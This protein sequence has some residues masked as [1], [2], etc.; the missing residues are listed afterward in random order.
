[1]T[2]PYDILTNLA[3]NLA[4][5]LL[6][7]GAS[8]LRDYAFGDAETRALRHAWEAAFRALL[9]SAVDEAGADVLETIFRNFVQAEGVAAALLDL[10]LAGGPP[11]L[12]L[13]R[14]RFDALDYDRAT[15]PVDFNTALCALTEGLSAALLAEAQTPDSPL[16]NRVSLVRTAAI[17]ALLRQ[18]HADVRQI[19]ATVARLEAQLPTAKYNLVF[20]GPASGFAVGDRAQA[21]PFAPPPA[22]PPE[23]TPLLGQAL[24]LLTS[25]ARERQPAPY[26]PADRDAYLQAVEDECKDIHLFYDTEKGATLPLE[27]IYV[28][29]KADLSSSAER[30]AS[31][32]LMKQLVEE[33]RAGDALPPEKAL[34]RV[35]ILD[36]YA[37]RYLIY[38]PKMQAELR[39]AA[40]EAQERT[41]HLAEIVRRYRWMVL[42]GDPGSGKST[43]ARW[44]AL[45][46][47]RALLAGEETLRVDGGHV[48]PDAEPGAAESLGAARLPVLVRIAEYAAARWPKPGHDTELRLLAYVGQRGGQ[49]SERATAFRALLRDYLEAG[50]VTFIL[51][52]LDE[53]TEY[54]QR[55]AIAA[56]IEGLIGAWVRDAA[57]RCPLDADYYPTLMAEPAG[58]QGNQALVTSRIVGYQFCPLHAALPHFVIQPMEDAAVRRFC[59]NWGACYGAPEQGAAL[60]AAVL[61]HPNPNVREQ[62]GRNPLL[63]TILAQVF[64]EN[65]AAGLPA[66]RTEL[67]REAETAVFR[68]RGA[69]WARLAGQL[70][71]RDLVA[72][73]RRITARVAF[74]LHANPDFPAALVDAGSV[75]QWLRTAVR[76]EPA[77]SSGRREDD[78]VRE[79]LAAAGRLS[80]FFVARGENAYGFLHRQFQEYFAGRYLA[81]LLQAGETLTPYLSRLEDPAWREVLLL[82]LGILEREAPRLT[83]KVMHSVLDASDPTGGLLPYT[84]LLAADALQELARPPEALVRRVA[85]GLITAYSRADEARFAALAKRVRATF[86][87]LPRQAQGRD[88]VGA[89]LCAALVPSPPALPI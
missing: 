21:Q 46:L 84:L 47:A 9:E 44:L 78:V 11:P 72:A 37:A 5:D 70:G 71:T 49:D 62:M 17:H 4:S 2:L 83:E 30:K 60:A 20:L 1:M 6:T 32:E 80:G 7:G 27:R 86:A 40:R 38:D 87:A 22:L 39:A 15:L 25:L 24:E 55:A 8:A 53:V 36:P 59:E 33:Q 63:L 18:Q 43:L 88:P 19:A 82:T 77:L 75:R 12:D 13:L 14:A 23:L 67:Y 29:L 35:M 16:Y 41:Y 28:A 34:A 45:H 76:D 42:L 73:L 89:A 69:E 85:A 54:D 56:E 65:P 50:R 81:T 74:N 10:A 57:G 68:Q 64:Q 66:R 58:W 48:R 26:T 79:L 61:K 52:G 31:Q 51:D 3:A